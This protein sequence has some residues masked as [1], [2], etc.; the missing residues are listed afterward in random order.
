[1]HHLAYENSQKSLMRVKNGSWKSGKVSYNNIVS[2]LDL[3]YFEKVLCY[4]ALF[5][6]V[7]LASIADYVKPV[8][9][10]DKHISSVF[11]IITEF[12]ENI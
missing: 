11:T 6:S 8:Y 7:Y 2:K 4:R 9:F 10:K 12:Y 1:M 5:D 3:D